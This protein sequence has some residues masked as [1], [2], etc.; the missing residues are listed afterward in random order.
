[1]CTL[2]SQEGGESGVGGG[3]LRKLS[4]R[5]N[6]YSEEI[7]G[8]LRAGMTPTFSYW[9]VCSEIKPESSSCVH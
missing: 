3:E 7:S 5:I 1:M 6:I 2:L 9:H 8:A 4:F